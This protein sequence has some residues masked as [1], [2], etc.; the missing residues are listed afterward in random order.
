[1]FTQDICSNL[2]NSL[3]LILSAEMIE[4]VGLNPNYFNGNVSHVY[5]ITDVSLS[6]IQRGKFNETSKQFEAPPIEL[7]TQFSLFAYFLVFWAILL[8]RCLTIFIVDFWMKNIPQTVTTWKRILHANQK[9][10]FPFPYT[11]WHQGSGSCQDHLKR[12]KA[13][14]VEVMASIAINLFFNMILLIPL[15]ILCK[16]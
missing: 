13:A 8:L 11:N 6:Y 4:I 1:M 3:Q 7:Y 16:Y 5:P 15:P 10:S 2:K 12:K 14:L 9:S